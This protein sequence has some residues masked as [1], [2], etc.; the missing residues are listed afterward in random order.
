MDFL[1]FK[2]NLLF[3]YTL[4]T[5]EIIFKQNLLLPS[6]DSTFEAE[7]SVISPVVFSTEEDFVVLS[8]LSSCSTMIDFE[9]LNAAI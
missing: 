5:L 8:L 7:L 6:N 3:L 1:N 4:G 9:L 2:N